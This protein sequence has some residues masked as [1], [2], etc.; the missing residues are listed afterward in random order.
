MADTEAPKDIETPKPVEAEADPEKVV[1]RKDRPTGSTHF[2]DVDFNEENPEEIA[3]ATWAE[4]Y[5]TCCCHTPRDWLI[6]FIFLVIVCTALY[7]FLFGLDM[8][9]NGA[10]VL[11]GCTSGN[12]LK[13]EQNPIAGLMIGILATVLLQSSSTTTSIVVSLVGEEVM[14]TKNG[15]YMIMGANIGTSVTNTIVSLGFLGDGDSLERAFAGAV[16]HDMFNFLTVAIMLPLEAATGV[17][18]HFTKAI[19]PSDV[20]KGEKWEGPIKK[21]VGP[22]TKEF[23]IVNKDVTKKVATGSKT[24]DS[25]FPVECENDVRDYKSCKKGQMG[26]ISCNKKNNKCP[27][28]F[29]I[30]SERKDDE[31]S[32]FVCLFIGLVVLIT[33]LLILVNVLQKML[34][35]TSTRILYKATNVNGY[36]GIAIGTG[37]TILVQSSSITT[38]ALTPLVGMGVI[39]LEQ[40]FPMTLGANIGTTVTGLLAAQVSGKKEALQVALAHLFF[41]I[42]GIIIW[43]P[44]PKIRQFPLYLATQLGKATRVWRGFPFVYLILAFF[45]FPVIMLGISLLFDQ[46][47]PGFKV[48]GSIIVI[49]IVIT[50][51]RIMWKVKYHGLDKSIVTYMKDRQARN[52]AYRTLPTELADIKQELAR[53]KEH[54]GLPDEEE[55]EIPPEDVKDIE[56]EVKEDVED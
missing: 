52:T 34:L 53:L 4:V 37:L 1:S 19:T 20:D 15:I 26:L 3:D 41:N 56:K 17:L 29:R 51:L 10:K 14:N 54:T 39:H 16:V 38:S 49:M 13:E 11:T 45:I 28:F 9:G 33:C 50:I 5:Q 12:I 46:D 23:I 27:M 2:G 36:I 48:L 44:I 40:M 47:S 6:I 8:L 24:C 55:P 7:F 18:Y 22:L 35:G 31:I 25:F 42:F 30:G 32:G 21:I 43:Y